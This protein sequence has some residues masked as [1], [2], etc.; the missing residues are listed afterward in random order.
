ML[1][2]DVLFDEIKQK[3]T[4]M[5]K[6][7]LTKRLLAAALA[8]GLTLTNAAAF[9]DTEGHWAK[10]AIS[11][12]SEDYNLINGYEDGTFRP[13]ASITR[14]A[15]AGIMDRFMHFQ[16]ASPAAT[17]ADTAG[18]Y[19]ESSILKLHAAGVY[20]GTEGKA[21][22][23]N[24]ITRQQAV[25]MIARAFGV[26]GSTTA[27]PYDDADQIAA[28]AQA[29]VAEMTARGYITDSAAG[30]FR[31]AAAI[32]RA[33]ILNILNNMIQVL[34]QEPETYTGSVPGTVMINAAEGAVLM[35]MTVS[36]DLILAP[37]VSGGVTLSNVT[38]EGS[39]RN[40]SGVTP[41]IITTETQPSTPEPSTP[42]TTPTPPET[43]YPW[44]A[45]DGYLKYDNYQVPLYSGVEKNELT[46]GDFVWDGDRVRYVGDA[47]RTQFGIDVSAYQNRAS[48]NT[49]IDW[50]AVAN[51]GVDFAMVRIGFRGTASGTLNT[52][53]FYGQNIDGAMAA[54][55]DTGVYFFSQA[56]SVAEAVEEADYIINLLRNHEISGPVAYDWEMHDS[57]Y[58][59]YGTSKELATACALAFCKRIESAGY[60]P[61]V[62]VSKYVGYN[63]L[64]LPQLTDYPIWFPEYKTASSEKLVPAFYYQMDIWQ[65]SSS[66]SI[67]GIGGRVDAN[68]RFR[69]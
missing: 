38:V 6:I 5:R 53:A 22:S 39:I 14:G 10:D 47:Y 3:G 7:R 35:D 60:Q 49:T 16:T 66:C 37:G 43:E 59:V 25:T 65:F 54:G 32:T 24:S 48:A 52:D 26:S 29:S 28:Y 1:F 34:I 36:G 55:I 44:V 17:F 45:A 46:T 20:L 50:D 33:E 18:T 56:I 13:D 23:A 64:N 51:D 41:T 61:M 63:K 67:A 68:I 11:K 57:T 15:F 8:V 19:W 27:L 30:S 4:A 12:W 62:Y 31:P 69:A 9:T 42:E 21:L 58:R 40:F 2:F